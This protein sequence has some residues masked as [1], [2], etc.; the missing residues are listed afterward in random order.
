MRSAASPLL[1]AMAVVGAALPARGDCVD[2]VEKAKLFEAKRLTRGVQD[3]DFVKAGR[4]EISLFGGYYVSDLLDGTFVLTGAYTYHLT[5]DVG[6]E[7]SFGWSRVTSSVSSKLEHDRAITVLPPEDRV[8]LIFANAV[9]APLHGKAQ[10]FADT[11]LHFDLYG[12]LG[13]GLID[14]STSFGAA[15]Q[16]GLGAKVFLGRAFAVRLD[17]RDYVYRQQVLATRQYVSD[18]A[19]TLGVSLFLPVTP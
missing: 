3:R 14:N 11:I 4:H 8:F 13:V 7:G 17:V 2:P 1:I 16:A 5:E 10:L 18:F 9:W 6:V 19:V 15:G 12:S